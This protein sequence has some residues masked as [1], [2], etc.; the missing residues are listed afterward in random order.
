M[1]AIAN[2]NGDPAV[3]MALT[4]AIENAIAAAG[5]AATGGAIGGGS[6]ALNGADISSTLQ[7]YNMAIFLL[8]QEAIAAGNNPNTLT[9]ADIQQIQNAFSN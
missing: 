6:G 7:Q 5:G 9:D 3:A 8:Q 2:S 4:N 1:W